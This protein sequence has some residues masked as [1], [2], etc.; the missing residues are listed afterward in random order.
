MRK[1]RV[2]V[3]RFFVIFFV[4]TTV[5]II[6]IGLN[7]KCVDVILIVDSFMVNGSFKLKSTKPRACLNYPM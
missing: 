6:Y 2:V 5:G 4:F 1:V 3:F 7:P